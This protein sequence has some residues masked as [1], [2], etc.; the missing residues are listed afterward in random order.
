ML[1]K[2]KAKITSLST[3]SNN[4]RGF[5]FVH[6]CKSSSNNW[7][8]WRISEF[9]FVFLGEVS[10]DSSW[11]DTLENRKFVIFLIC[12]L[13]IS[14][15]VRITI[16]HTSWSTNIH[17]DDIIITCPINKHVV[18]PRVCTC[19]QKSLWY[20]AFDDWLCSSIIGSTFW[21]VIKTLCLSSLVYDW[22][23]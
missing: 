8:K 18:A 4:I 23:I 15:D 2:G 12:L 1:W 7:R 10:F 11:E 5:I 13:V 21:C 14:I 20:A 9:F 17:P 3:L 16:T 22:L 19:R 6:Q